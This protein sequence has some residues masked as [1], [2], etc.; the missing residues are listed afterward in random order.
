MFGSNEHQMAPILTTTSELNGKDM[1]CYM[2]SELVVK[3]LNGEYKVRNPKLKILWLK[4]Q[5]L[6]TFKG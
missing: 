4:V 1:S 3:H 6:K 5:E 2:D